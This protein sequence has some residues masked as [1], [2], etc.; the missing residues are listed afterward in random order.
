MGRPTARGSRLFRRAASLRSVTVEIVVPCYNEAA[1]LDVP[2]FQRA[3][4]ADPEL[5]LLF[6]DDGSTDRTA[7]VLAELVRTSSARTSAVRSV[8]PSSTKRSSSSGSASSARWKAGT[9]SRAASL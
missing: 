9:S 3:L 5:E 1:R 8:L 4:E 7:E 6:V 2:A